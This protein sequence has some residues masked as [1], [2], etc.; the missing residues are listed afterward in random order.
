MKSK[1]VQ[2][3]QGE[4]AQKQDKLFTTR[5]KEAAAAAETAMKNAEKANQ[6][7]ST[8]GIVNPLGLLALITS[9]ALYVA[10]GLAFQLEDA[11]LAKAGLPAELVLTALP[12]LAIAGL[13]APNAITSLRTEAVKESLRKIQS[14]SNTLKKVAQMD[15]KTDGA[16]SRAEAIA[17][18]Q[19]A[20]DTFAND[21]MEALA[22]PERKL[23]PAVGKAALAIV[24]AA[25]A[26]EAA[27]RAK[28]K[29]RAATL[30]SIMNGELQEEGAERISA[31]AAKASATP[32]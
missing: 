10:P 22:F 28:A 31:E 18:A 14:A 8:E 1:L 7:M 24:E 11:F 16:S 30:T 3:Q 27:A 26:E 19:K 13:V 23:L 9:G 4:W 29:T 20:T 25:E 17:A 32:N 21:K 12:A 2:Q 15:V 5:V 6:L